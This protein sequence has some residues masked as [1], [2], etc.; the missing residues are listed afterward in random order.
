MGPST[1]GWLAEG[2][3]PHTQH[4]A[5]QVTAAQPTGPLPPS[6]Q[7][8]GIGRAWGLAPRSEGI[9]GPEPWNSACVGNISP[10]PSRAPGSQEDG[11]DQ[12]EGKVERAG[13]PVRAGLA[14]PLCTGCSDDC[15]P[16]T[17]THQ[18]GFLTA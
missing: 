2:Q 14:K 3:T 17:L 16:N 10:D 6:G 4:P 9:L 5:G 15:D 11:P 13:K 18:T 1:V 7:G 8:C 12:V